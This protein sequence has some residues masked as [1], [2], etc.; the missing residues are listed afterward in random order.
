[1]S[2]NN[3]GGLPVVISGAAGA[4]KGTVLSLLP[5][6]GETYVVSISET[7]RSPRPGDIH[8]INYYFISREEF[9]ENIR[10]G[11]YI[12]YTEYSGNYYGTPK[13]ST[14]EKLSLGY[15]VIFEIEVEGAVN[16]KKYY[17]QAL[18]VFISPPTY[19][20][21]EYR[22]RDR[23]TETEEAVRRR[24]ET[25]KNE[26]QMI[27]IYDYLLINESGKQKKLAETLENIIHLECLKQKKAILNDNDISFLEEYR[28]NNKDKKEKFLCEYY[29]NK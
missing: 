25:S 4:G 17:P 27:D 6:R 18:M 24:L 12:E 13:D 23:G 19:E 8:G 16:I 20:E 22:L 7:S 11:K 26:I 29:K 2:E 15:N 28:I 3:A 10:R 21:L 1:M 5:G 14:E 9:E